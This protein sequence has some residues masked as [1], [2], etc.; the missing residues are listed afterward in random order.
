MILG[1]KPL[2][3]EVVLSQQLTVR[4]H[5]HTSHNRWTPILGTSCP[6]HADAA[7]ELHRGVVFNPSRFFYLAATFAYHPEYTVSEQHLPDL[8]FKLLV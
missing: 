7:R 6:C 3:S 4:S 2:I 8:P 1:D 5:L